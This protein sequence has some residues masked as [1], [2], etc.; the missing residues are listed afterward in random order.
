M[1]IKKSVLASSLL[2]AMALSGCSTSSVQEHAEFMEQ[3]ETKQ[4]AKAEATFNAMPDWFLNPPKNNS[5]GIYGV[6]TATSKNLQ[7]TLNLAKLNA[8][9]SIAKTLNQ[10]VSGRERA[11]MA[12]SENGNVETDSESV[13]TKFVDSADIVGVN[14]VEAKAELNGGLYTVY[15]LIHLSYEEQAKIIGRK[16]NSTTKVSAKK[17]YAEIE[18]ELLRR[19]KERQ[20]ATDKLL[21]IENS[22]S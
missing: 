16:A 15:T 1:N 2:M 11:Y 10:E 12:S 8:E 18:Q 3:Q 5:K 9:F 22:N 7:H 13:I 6:G 21:L 4:I 19:A 20:T 17:A 14:T